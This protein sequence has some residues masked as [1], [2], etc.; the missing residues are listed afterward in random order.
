MDVL[1]APDWRNG[2]PYQQLLADALGKEGVQVSFLQNY[3]RV[4]PLARLLGQRGCDVLHLHWPEAYYPRMDDCWDWFRR[5]RFATDLKLAT[6]RC[7]LVVTAHNL[8]AHDRADEPFASRNTR[9][10]FHRAGTIIAHSPAA[11]AQI[12]TSFRVD[13]T[14]VHVI[15]HGDLS[16][17]IETPLPREQA[18]RELGLGSGKLCLMFGALEPYK[19]IEEV[20]DYWRN[21]RP[22]T[23]L[24]IAGKPR[25]EAYGDDL[26]AVAA[27]VANVSL[28]FAWL[29]DRQ[30]RLWLSA[31]ECVLFNYRQIFTSGAACLSRSLGVPIL[32]PSRLKTVDLA[33]PS[34]LVFRFEAFERDFASQLARAL[35]T[36]TNY[37]A[38]APWREHTSWRGVAAATKVAYVQA[39]GAPK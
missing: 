6:R 23:E 2:V 32:L 22:A 7:A 19:G 1:F 26:R 29:D 25:T 35:E 9:A 11:R 10:A 38:A 4:L 39:L 14:K 3:R 5:A 21:A 13:E 24:V 31:V 27:D 8:H 30:L 12:A 28:R 36:P 37:A 34:P 20:L 16:A 18:R 17:V 33:E 15:P